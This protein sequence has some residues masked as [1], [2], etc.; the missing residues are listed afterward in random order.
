MDVLPV[1]VEL[2]VFSATG[3]VTVTRVR[4]RKFRAVMRRGQP[5]AAKRAHCAKRNLAN[6]DKGS[7]LGSMDADRTYSVLR[8]RR[9]KIRTM[10]ERSEIR[11]RSGLFSFTY[12][13]IAAENLNVI[14]H[15]KP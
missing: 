8:P 11:P 9:M 12:V 6:V 3:L 1:L 10:I 4:A 13:R 14:P 5:E 7:E 15:L 2:K